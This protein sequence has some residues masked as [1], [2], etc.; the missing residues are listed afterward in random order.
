M[1]HSMYR[2][3][4]MKHSR[5]FQSLV[6]LRIINLRIYSVVLLT[7]K[8]MKLRSPVTEGPEWRRLKPAPYT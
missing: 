7:W 3:P 5:L 8:P 1:V 4:E 6:L 2:F